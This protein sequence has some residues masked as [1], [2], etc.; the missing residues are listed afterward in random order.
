MSTSDLFRK[1]AI[2]GLR[3]QTAAH[4]ETW[5]LGGEKE[6]FVD[7]DEGIIEFLFENGV[8]ATAPVQIIGTLNPGDGTFL[9]GWDHPSVEPPLQRAAWLVKEYGEENDIA[10]FT[11]QKV[12]CNEDEAWAFTALAARLDGANGAY[13][14]DAGGP[15]VYMTF[16]S[17][18]LGKQN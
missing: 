3:E 18:T 9:W 13:R 2:E 1:Q 4:M 15:Y 10:A 6:W 12:P 14:A 11:N 16:G 7:Q 8:V 5:N 17:V